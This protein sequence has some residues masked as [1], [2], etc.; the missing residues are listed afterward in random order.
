M[1][2]TPHPTQIRYLEAEDTLRVLFSDDLEV[3]LPTVYLRGF[4]P[5]ALCQGHQG[6]DPRWIPITSRAMIIVEDVT[7]VGAYAICIR[8]R[9]GHDTGIHTFSSLRALKPLIEAGLPPAQTRF[10]G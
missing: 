6:G 10:E 9:D 1:G 5:C 7:P 3:D 8:W 2:A 4:C